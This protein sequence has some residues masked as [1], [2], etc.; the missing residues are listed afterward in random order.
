MDCREAEQFIHSFINDELIG[1][2]LRKFLMHVKNCG[3]CYEE[4]ETEYLLSEAFDRVEHGE[5][6]H[7]DREL[8]AKIARAEHSLAI[9][10]LI[11]NC[12]RTLE[13]VAILAVIVELIRLCFLYI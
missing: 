7:L 1:E 11:A 6:F 3:N 5:A 12:R 4:L 10:A 13:T 9:H 8:S 2:E